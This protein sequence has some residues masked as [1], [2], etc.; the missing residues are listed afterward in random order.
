MREL[1]VDS[2]RVTDESGRTRIYDYAILIG[3][4]D[5]GPFFCESYGVKIAER[6]TGNLSLV[7]NVTTSAARID[8]LMDLLLR[9]SVLPGHLLDI[10]ADWL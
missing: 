3:E 4:Q 2:R 7:P 8:A 5:M 9:N 6:G 1:L 10:I